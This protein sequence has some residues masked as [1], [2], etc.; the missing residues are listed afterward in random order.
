MSSA[1]PLLFTVAF[2]RKMAELTQE[3]RQEWL[4]SLGRRLRAGPPARP[5]S[6]LVQELREVAR[7]CRLPLVDGIERQLGPFDPRHLTAL[8]EVPRER[9]VRIEDIE[10]SAEDVPLPLDDQGLATISAPH[11]Y[12]LSYRLLA[13][14]RGDL[15]VELGSGSGYGSALAA[16]I[17]EESGRVLSFEI[18]EDLA[19]WAARSLDGTPNVHVVRA[20]AMASAPLWGAAKKVVAT[21]AVNVLPAAWIDALPEGG[22]LVAPV[23]PSDRDQKLVLAVRRHGRVVE[24]EHGAVRYVRNRSVR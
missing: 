17:V 21:F 3:Q 15:L 23:G 11:A 7:G 20:D 2:R 22:R 8:L 10:R 24:S 19:A 18:D 4:A 1:Q 9:F 14:A 6:P 5:G 16:F 12:A 13:L